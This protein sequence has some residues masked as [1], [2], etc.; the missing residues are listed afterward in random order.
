MADIVILAEE[1]PVGG[2]NPELLV[3]Q[4]LANGIQSS[5]SQAQL[6][7]HNVTPEEETTARVLLA[8]HDSAQLSI[9]EIRVVNQFDVDARFDVSVLKNK[10]PA[11]IYTSVQA[12]IDGWA[13]LAEAQAD[14][15]EWLP[16]V[17]ATIAWKVQHD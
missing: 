12:S 7:L 14:L 15:R 6:V 13:N 5:L 10:T 9:S 8:A 2:V 1:F 3:E 16:L 17:F 11:Q 4:L